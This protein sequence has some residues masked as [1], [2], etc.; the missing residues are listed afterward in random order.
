[1]MFSLYFFINNFINLSDLKLTHFTE[2][3]M[4]TNIN[5]SFT[6]IEQRKKQVPA[7]M[8]DFGFDSHIPILMKV[9]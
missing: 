9:I 2:K 4:T 5:A 3:N 6:K 7:K 8:S 1:M